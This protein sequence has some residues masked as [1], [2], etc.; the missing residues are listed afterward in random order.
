LGSVTGSF[1]PDPLVRLQH[2]LVRVPVT[3]AKEADVA[4]HEALLTPPRP[5][6]EGSL[7]DVKGVA[8]GTPIRL[9]ESGGELQEPDSMPVP[10]EG[11]E[12]HTGGG[13]FPGDVVESDEEVHGYLMRRRPGLS[14]TPGAAPS[15]ANP[16][17]GAEA[18]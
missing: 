11:L 2:G 3:V 14:G 6:R 12:T 1:L 15:S 5:E 13:G 16:R 18:N 9:L 8:A 7:E 4:R 17:W 10:D